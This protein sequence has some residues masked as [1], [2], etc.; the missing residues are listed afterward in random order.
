MQWPFSENRRTRQWPKA[1]L[2]VAGAVY[3]ARGRISVIRGTLF[4][5]DIMR[6]LGYRQQLVGMLQRFWKRDRASI[7]AWLDTLLRRTT[8]PAP[9]LRHAWRSRNTSTVLQQET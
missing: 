9:V 1:M 3:Q 4:R 7:E 2:V 8:S 5:N 6:A